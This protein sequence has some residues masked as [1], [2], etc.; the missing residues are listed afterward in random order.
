ML[1]FAMKVALAAQTIDDADYAAPGAKGLRI[2]SMNI[3]VLG[4]LLSQDKMTKSAIDRQG[5]AAPTSGAGQA[6]FRSGKKA[7]LF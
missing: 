3:P 6:N 4:I 5:R 2:G 7:V 1:D